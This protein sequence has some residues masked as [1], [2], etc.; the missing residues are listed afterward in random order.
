MSYGSVE[1][2]LICLIQILIDNYAICMS[3]M[4]E[5]QLM[6]KFIL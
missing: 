5:Q 6:D 3:Y 4:E 2:E 1:H